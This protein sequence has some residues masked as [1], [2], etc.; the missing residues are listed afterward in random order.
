[1]EQLKA[2]E[3][4]LVSTQNR[5]NRLAGPNRAI[6][7]LASSP[8]LALRAPIRVG[9]EASVDRARGG[10]DPATGQC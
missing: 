7:R 2:G 5:L 9:R 4:G 1:M 6:T 10:V 3:P 8:V